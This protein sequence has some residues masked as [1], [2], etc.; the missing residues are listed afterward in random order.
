MESHIKLGKISSWCNTAHSTLDRRRKSTNSQVFAEEV[1]PTGAV[2]MELSLERYR[3]A[4]LPNMHLVLDECNSTAAARVYRDRYP[5]RHPS[6]NI[7]RKLDR[8]IRETGSIVPMGAFCQNRGR[9]RTTRTPQIEEAVLNLF[10]T[11]IWCWCR[12]ADIK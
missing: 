4:A 2:P 9:S 12:S 8:R 7:F 10:W 3:H 5:L 11:N 1:E 6:C